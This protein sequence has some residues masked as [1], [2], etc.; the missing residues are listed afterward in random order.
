M[1]P[2][3]RGNKDDNVIEGMKGP[4]Q[5]FGVLPVPPEYRSLADTELD[6]SQQDVA[7]L[8]AAYAHDRKHGTTTAANF[9]DAVRQHRIIDEM[10]VVEGHIFGSK[11]GGSPTCSGV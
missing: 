4:S 1:E 9:G 11:V 8:Y 5:S 2:T 6:V 7:Y 10:L 3:S